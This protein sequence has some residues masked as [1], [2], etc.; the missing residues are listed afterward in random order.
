MIKKRFEGKT[1]LRDI[2]NEFVKIM[3]EQGIVVQAYSA[4]STNSLY[5]KLDYGVIGTVRFSDHKGKPEYP[6]KFQVRTDVKVTKKYRNGIFHP[7]GIDKLISHITTLKNTR[8]NKYG[9]RSY[10]WYMRKNYY[11]NKNTRG[12]WREAVTLNPKDFIK[13]S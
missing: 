4:Y 2:A 3:L 6:Y 7:K 12:F 13:S 5:V 10:E 11:D 8:I 1:E 9:A